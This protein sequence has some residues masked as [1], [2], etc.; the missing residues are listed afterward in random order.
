LT[1][2]ATQTAGGSFN[3]FRLDPK[4]AATHKTNGGLEESCILAGQPQI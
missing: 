4:Q 2:L 3:H 1:S